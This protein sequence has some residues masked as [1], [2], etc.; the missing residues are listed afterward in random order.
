VDHSTLAH[1]GLDLM[2]ILDEAE[3]R[4]MVD[5]TLYRLELLV[6]HITSDLNLCAG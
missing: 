6:G 1:A 4:R 5:K 2:R 3:H